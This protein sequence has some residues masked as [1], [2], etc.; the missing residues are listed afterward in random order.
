MTRRIILIVV[1]ALIVL[2]LMF[3][4]W[5]W[6]F[7][8]Q[9]EV[10]ENLGGFGAGE[11]RPPGT[12]VDPGDGGTQTLIGGTADT[13]GGNVQTPLYVSPAYI[14]PTTGP[15]DFEPDD[16]D[17]DVPG[18]S[19]LDGSGGGG[20]AFDPTP[21]NQ[22]NNVNIEGT[23]YFT[24]TPGGG[25]SGGV[26]LGGS[27]LGVAGGCV[28]QYLTVKAGATLTTL[29]NRGVNW[30]VSIF[31]GGVVGREEVY[32][33]DTD[34]N[35][36]G[37][38]LI[39]CM[40][41]S[42]AKIAIQQITAQTV[43]WINSGFNGEPAFVQDFGKFF[44]DVADRAAGDVIQ[45]SDLSFLCSPFQLQ[46]RIAIAQS[47]A[48]R[49]SSAA[50]QSCTLT[51]VVG[52]VENFMSGTFSEGGWPGLISFTTVPTN[53]P[54]GAYAS[55]QVVLNNRIAGDIELADRKISLGGFL[56]QE[57]CTG[58]L[59]LRTGKNG[60]PCKIISHGSTIEAA[61]DS[62]IEADLRGLELAS[63]IDQILSALLNSLVTN[64]FQK[65]LANVSGRD[66]GGLS[67][68][69]AQASTEA[70]VLLQ[71]LQAAV[72]RAQQYASVQQGSIQDIQNAQQNLT[73]LQ[74]CWAGKNSSNAA[75]AEAQ[76]Q[77]LEAR[78][79]GYN[80]NITRANTAIA[81]VAQI[82]TQALSAAD[83]TGVRAAAT[84]LTQ[85]E[86][87]GTLIT[88]ADVTLAQQNRTT[89]QSEMAAINQQTSLGLNQCYAS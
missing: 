40:V 86:G 67:A 15:E 59:D 10:Q 55:A 51:D 12:G 28:A 43:N 33:A 34:A 57:E 49:S 41:R 87:L 68:E 38:A 53:N 16:T 17:F 21:I 42:L 62:V 29:A 72:Q 78:V 52:N 4:L 20:V 37:Q 23:A 26:G 85:A 11:D 64:I 3:V 83:V 73:N 7:G 79:P 77:T 35:L 2:A 25:G 48:R 89:L 61:L 31:T 69:D 56:A 63:S 32:D 44:T 80:S 65:G 60:P 30:L 27:L 84:A 70:G 13:Q 36:Q 18:V 5:F 22:I 58:P 45:G 74:N 24:G 46:V 8:K 1:G 76:I 66:V 14:P 6:L 19:W 39:D 47:Y 9:A 75:A 88:G 71:A 81:R 50:A 54:F 82:Q